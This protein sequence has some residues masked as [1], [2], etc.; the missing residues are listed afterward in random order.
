M[1][2]TILEKGNVKVSYKQELKEWKAREPEKGDNYAYE[3]WLEEKPDPHNNPDGTPRK[4]GG[5]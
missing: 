5:K 4:A 1:V 3:R 2:Q